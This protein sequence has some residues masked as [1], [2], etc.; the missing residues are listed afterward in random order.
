MGAIETSCFTLRSNA[1][2]WLIAPAVDP[3]HPL[4]TGKP[5]Y[6]ALGIVLTRDEFLALPALQATYERRLREWGENSAEP[7]GTAI[8]LNVPADLTAVVR[9]RPAS[10]FYLPAGW[11]DVIAQAEPTHRVYRYSADRAFLLSRI[12]GSRKEPLPPVPA[13]W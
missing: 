4:A 12:A 1:I 2:V 7:I 10:D 6:V 13:R 5:Y 9:A 8:M 11:S 3:S